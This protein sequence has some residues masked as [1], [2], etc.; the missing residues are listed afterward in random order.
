[1]DKQDKIKKKAEEMGSSY[2]KFVD[3]YIVSL[4]SRLGEG[5]FGVVWSGANVSNDELVAVK[6]ISCQKLQK[7]P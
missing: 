3:P 6:Q 4:N 5:S 2:Y 7:D 1:M